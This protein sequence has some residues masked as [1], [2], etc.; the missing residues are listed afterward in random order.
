MIN[1][2]F[3]LVAVVSVFL[4]VAVGMGVALTA[5]PGGS[6]ARAE[7]EHAD[8]QRLR[9]QVDRLE[10][11]ESGADDFA[12]GVAETILSGQIGRAHV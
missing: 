9:D 7:A 5:G 11:A 4:A 12:A 2:R 8:A 6:F 1:H 3:H 10:T